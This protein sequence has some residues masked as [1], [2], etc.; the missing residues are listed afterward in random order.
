[1]RRKLDILCYR[2]FG[3]I[4]QTPYVLYVSSFTQRLCHIYQC[5]LPHTVD[6][7][8]RLGVKKDRLAQFVAPV[9]IMR[10]PAKTCL[11]AS[12]D[13]RCGIFK[14]TPYKVAVYKCRTVRALR[15]FSAGSVIVRIAELFCSGIVGDHRIHASAA[16][17]PK[18]LRLTQPADIGV[19]VDIGLSYHSDTIPF[20]LK[21]PSDH[22]H[23]N[24]RR[25]Y[26]GVSADYDHIQLLPAAP[27]HLFAC[28]DQ[29]VGFRKTV[30]ITLFSS[31][32]LIILKSISNSLSADS[33]PLCRLRLSERPWL[34]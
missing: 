5:Y 34:Q 19:T 2:L 14:I 11:D 10:D 29:K 32:Q 9:V 16:H 30:V 27:L 18:Q 1:M 7:Q 21:D 4:A 26:I 12:K 25:I 6:H 20:A 13:D 3:D 22:R 23:P 24:K 8:I 17:S 31:A 15:I 33:A 28:S